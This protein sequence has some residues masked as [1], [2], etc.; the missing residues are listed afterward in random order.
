MRMNFDRLEA[1]LQN[2][3]EGSAARLFSFG[4]PQRD[5]GSRV[6]A[7]MKDNIHVQ[8]DGS[9]WAPNLYILVAPPDQAGVLSQNQ[10]LVEEISAL[11]YQEGVQAGLKFVTAPRIKVLPNPSLG[12][13]QLQ[14]LAQYTL[15]KLSETTDMEVQPEDDQKAG[16]VNAFLIVNGSQIFPL[17]QNVLNIGR[18][19]DNDLVVGDLKVSRSHAQLR[20]I[21]GRYIIFDL[22][23]SGGTFVNEKRITQSALYPG[24][25]IS[26]AGVPLIFGYDHSDTGQTQK[27]DPS[28][29]SPG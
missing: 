9:E 4:S 14:V 21:N 3:I 26:L 15:N 2:L 29:D 17:S 11:I 20:C 23:S 16:A 8:A 18:G 22:G 24:D 13:R 7:A 1:R 5:L 25:V 10:A 28:M 19:A 12:P 27:Y 6:T